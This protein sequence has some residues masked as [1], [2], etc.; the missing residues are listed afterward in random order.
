MRGG[1]T[2]SLC[3]SPRGGEIGGWVDVDSLVES[4]N[5]HDREK[6][7]TYDDKID[8][9]SPP[10]WIPACAGMTVV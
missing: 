5:P 8:R 2:P 3:L 6:H 9:L 4:R 7:L 10:L 1:R